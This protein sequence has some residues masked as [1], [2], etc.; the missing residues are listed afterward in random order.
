MGDNANGTN[1]AAETEAQLAEMWNV[2]SQDI[3][4]INP[5]AL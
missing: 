3:V 2:A 1:L 5:G 4:Q